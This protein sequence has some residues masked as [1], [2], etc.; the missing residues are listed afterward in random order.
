MIRQLIGLTG[1]AVAIPVLVAW[2]KIRL[3]R[4]QESRR[5]EGR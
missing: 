4:W 5:R 3:W 1:F 2:G